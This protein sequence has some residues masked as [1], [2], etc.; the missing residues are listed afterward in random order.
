[1]STEAKPNLQLEIA[2]VLFMDVVGYSKLLIDEQREV[3]DELNKIVRNTR[4]FSAAEAAGQLTRIPTGDGMALVFTGTL[5]APVQCALEIAEALRGGPEIPVRMG[6]H[7]GP[8]SGV[9]DVNGHTNVA[10]SGINMAQ[11]VMDCGDANHILLSK[12]VAED[13]AQYRQWRSLL[14]DLGEC[15]VKHDVT[16][17]VVN[18][19]NDQL[20]NSRVPVKFAPTSTRIAADLTRPGRRRIVLALVLALCA[21]IGVAIVA[22]IFTPAL[23]KS[24][25]KPAANPS[26]APASPGTAGTTVSAIPENSIA[27]LP[28][29]NLSSDKDNAFFA[30]GIQDEIITALSKISGLRVISRTSTVQYQSAPANLPQIARQLRVANVLEG[31]VQKAADRVH[32][33]VQLI[34]ADTDAHLWAQS[35]DRQLTDIFGV[36]A[37]VAKTIA[38]SLQ[39]TL[40]PQEKARVETKPTNNADAYVLYLRGRDYQTRPDTLL[41]DALNAERCYEQAIALDPAFALAHARLSTVEATIYHWFEPTEK[42]RNKM[43]QEADRALQLQPNLGEAHLALALCYYYID[44]DYAAALRELDIAAAALPTDADVDLYIAAIHRRQGHINESLAIYGRAGTIDPRNS[45]VLEDL[46]QTLLLIRDWKA[47]GQAMDH[48]LE[49]SPDAVQ[50]RIQRAYVAYLAS[51]STAQIKSTLAGIP[52][53]IDPDGQV[54]FARWDVS[55]MNR[56]PAGAL[57]ALASTPLQTITTADGSPVPKVYLQACAE[58]AGGDETRAKADFEAARPAIEQTAASSPNDPFRRG[59]LGLLYAFLGRKEDALR[60]GRRVVEIRPRSRDLVDGS[61]AEAF[62]CLIYGRLGMA[63]EALPLIERMLTEPGGVDYAHDSIT[64]SDLRTRWEWD[65][66]RKD[67]RFARIIA[68]PEPKTIYQ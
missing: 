29:E 9:T 28:F 16:V 35:Y 27:V 4:A 42:R 55:L 24:L 68:G 26:P 57:K 1:M 25:H 34:R 39:A 59:H 36:E 20:G 11:R 19:Y 52:A 45:F 62:L 47:T 21:L 58:L 32:I 65:P 23:L 40:S 2:H 30:R 64:L 15:K 51:G 54:T 53:N 49:I 8:V 17:S 43:R 18:L 60:E 67:S 38:D 56:D 44:E 7:S 3:L 12:R 6:I 5:E 33:N 48:L 50:V 37:E 63:D 66:I 61:A 46:C 10:G 22:I 41:Q 13:L 14:H 31:S